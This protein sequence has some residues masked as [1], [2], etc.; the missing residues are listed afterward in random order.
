MATTNFVTSQGYVTASVTNGLATTTYVNT[1]TNGFVTSSVTNG[2]ATTTYVNTTAL[3]AGP[4]GNTDAQLVT[5][6]QNMTWG[7]ATAKPAGAGAPAG[8]YYYFTNGYP[9][10]GIISTNN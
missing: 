2:L 1:A 5:N 6:L 8:V 4:G 3:A 10:F 9:M 7:T